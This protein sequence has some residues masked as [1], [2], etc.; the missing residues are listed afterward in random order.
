[1]Y[2]WRVA[3]Y[4]CGA[5]GLL[6]A[7]MVLKLKNS[8]SGI[9]DIQVIYIYIYIYMY[10]SGCQ[11]QTYRNIYMYTYVFMFIYIRIYVCIHI[12]YMYVYVY[13]YIYTYV[14]IYVFIYMYMRNWS[15]TMKKILLEN[16]HKFFIYIHTHR[17]Q[18]H[19]YRMNT[20][21][22]TMNA[23]IMILILI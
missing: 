9:N 10:I 12:I 3:F 5:P 20:I 7:A 2:S 23:I 17:K 13:M 16:L 11:L 15:R 21:K 6:V 1:M 18:Q 8:P 4:V 14:L 19:Q 22:P